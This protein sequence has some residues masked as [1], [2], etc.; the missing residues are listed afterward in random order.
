[1]SLSSRL[2]S[3]RS[4]GSHVRRRIPRACVTIGDAA[5]PHGLGVAG[6]NVGAERRAWPARG[7]NPGVTSMRGASD[8]PAACSVGGVGACGSS[9]GMRRPAMP[10][11]LLDPRV[12]AC[13]SIVAWTHLAP[14]AVSARGSPSGRHSPRPR[15]MIYWRH[16]LQRVTERGAA[17]SSGT[18]SAATRASGSG[19]VG[20]VSQRLMVRRVENRVR[21]HW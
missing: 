13:Q 5:S 15:A 17:G 12:V 3:V 2:A 1:M 11:R 7:H 9:G 16:W 10:P 20:V 8:P 18:K 21:A 4:H 6:E 14:S 19:V